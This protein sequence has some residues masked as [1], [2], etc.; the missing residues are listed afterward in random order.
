MN[1]LYFELGYISKTTGL[2]G[3]VVMH[4]DADN[5][6]IFADQKVF[7]IEDD[8]N[9]LPHFSEDCQY[10]PAGRFRIKF[11]GFDSANDAE[12]LLGRKI[13]L[14]L[15]LLPPLVGN[16]FYYHEIIGFQ[17]FDKEDGLLGTIKSVLDRPM[18]PLIAVE[19]E[20]GKE[21]LIP[22]DDALI[23]EIDR[24]NSLITFNLPA[25]LIDLYR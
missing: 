14:P 7:Y 21:A 25:G 22:I 4:P 13:F 6:E 18:Q 23:H 5:P 12:V 17:A 10:D 2:K 3:Y 19:L 9:M 8:G 11:E 20:N 15:N 16:A 24:N 1:P